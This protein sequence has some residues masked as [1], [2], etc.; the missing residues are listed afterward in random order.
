MGSQLRSNETALLHPNEAPSPER[1]HHARP[2]PDSDQPPFPAGTLLA[3]TA[4]GLLLGG[5]AGLALTG[6]GARPSR[7]GRLAAIGAGLLATSVLA[8]SAMEHYRG[9]YRKA[10]MPVAP[11]A[12]LVTL[13]TA[14]AAA[15]S[16]SGALVKST[17][18]GGAV[19][20][21]LFGLGFHFAN[22]TRRPGGLSWN[23]L[24]YRAPFGA[25][26]A[27]ALAGLAG[28]GAIGADWKRGKR[29]TRQAGSFMG[30]VTALG[31]FGLTAEIALLHFRGAFHNRLMYAPV[32]AVPLTGAAIAVATARP[33][34]GRLDLVRTSLATTMTLG[35]V[36]TGLHAYGV[37]RGMGGFRNWT[38]NLFQGPPMAAPP[39]LTGIGLMGLSAIELISASTRHGRRRHG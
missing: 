36:G 22:I 3:L 20:T 15:V 4:A 37:S 1:G 14:T 23:N 35:L 9:N 24:F 7:A 2:A 12:A 17:L 29:A 26:G 31:L 38:Q 21:G 5:A 34:P 18:F 6:R 10:A 11:L 27:L 30:A 8:D 39:S 33:S 28:L 16:R 25:P 19:T 32:V 13:A